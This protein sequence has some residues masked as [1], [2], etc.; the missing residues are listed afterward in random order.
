MTAPRAIL[1]RRLPRALSPREQLWAL[2]AAVALGGA[3]LVTGVIGPHRRVIEQREGHIRL[4]TRRL[5]AAR[6]GA[7]ATP[8]PAGALDPYL[9]E[10]PDDLTLPEE[11]DRLAQLS[12]LR[13]ELRPSAEG[14]LDLDTRGPQP[15]MLAWLDALLTLRYPAAMEQLRLMGDGAGSQV[16]AHVRLRLAGA[17]GAEPSE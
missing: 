12:G 11:V 3:A 1:S 7:E 5:D 10:P 15:Q 17:A 4:L 9:L 13:V 16:Q 14:V 6:R 2:G 8:A